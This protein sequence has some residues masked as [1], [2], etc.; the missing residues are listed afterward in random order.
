MCFY[1]KKTV[2]CSLLS[3]SDTSS[4]QEPGE[5]LATEAIEAIHRGASKTKCEYE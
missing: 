4:G 1:E 3:G 2:A 5:S